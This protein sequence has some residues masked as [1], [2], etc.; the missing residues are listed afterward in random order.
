VRCIRW[1]LGGE[2][3]DNVA[4][5]VALT[6]AGATKQEALRVALDFHPERHCFP[7]FLY[8][9]A[10]CV[11]FINL[12]WDKNRRVPPPIGRRKTAPVANK[13]GGIR[14][15]RPLIGWEEDDARL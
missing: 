14:R 11:T 12:H 1:I 9:K 3:H 5:A 6:R 4:T 10:E 7:A 13:S 8:Y 15:Q 2:R